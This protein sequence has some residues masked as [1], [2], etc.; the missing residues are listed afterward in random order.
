MAQDT[1]EK[2][3]VAKIY[4]LDTLDTRFTT[5]SGVPYRAIVD[6]REVD[7]RE[8]QLSPLRGAA[9]EESRWGT[10]EFWLY[11]LVIAV[12]LPAMFWVAYDVSRRKKLGSLT[13]LDIWKQTRP[14][15][16]TWSGG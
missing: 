4:D 5:P 1:K 16:K 3:L 6:S 11:Y 2:S 10:P 9:V 8:K 13:C 15:K 7:K 12:A 14:L